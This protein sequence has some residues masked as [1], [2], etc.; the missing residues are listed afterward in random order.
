MRRTAASREPFSSS[1][2]DINMS[3]RIYCLEIF[4]EFLDLNNFRVKIF[5]PSKGKVALA[6]DNYLIIS[7]G[8]A[9]NKTT[10]VSRS[11]DINTLVEFNEQSGKPTALFWILEDRICVGYDTGAVACFDLD[12]NILFERIFANVPVQVM[13]VSG[14]DTCQESDPEEEGLLWIMF[15]KG[16]L[17]SVIILLESLTFST[18]LR[19][20]S[21]ILHRTQN[22]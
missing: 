1:A 16:L 21:Y 14:I 2:I 12:G 5:A 18:M 8:M 11:D 15:A 7:D 20:A 13:R 10:G 22:H 3:S 6:N 4:G 9:V 19:T 17:V